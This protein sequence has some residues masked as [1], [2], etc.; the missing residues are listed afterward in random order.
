MHIFAAV[1]CYDGKVHAATMDAFLGEMI[2][3]CHAGHALQVQRLEGCSSIP[4][5]RNALVFDFL[6]SKAD[7]LV[8]I[9]SDMAWSPGDLVRLASLPHDIV[10]GAY[11]YKRDGAGFIVHWDEDEPQLWADAHGAMRVKGLGCG[12]LAISR[13]ALLAIAEKSPDRWYLDAGEKV[14]AYFDMPFADGT[15]W[16]EDLRFCELARRANIPIHVLPEL[17]LTHCAGPNLGFKG[18]LG[19]WLRARM[20]NDQQQRVA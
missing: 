10:G 15:L 2:M 17:E 6:K 7:R 1:P 14:Y 11:R 3:A 12:F 13:K 19:D 20:A 5:A 18:R 9:D 8:F 16:G 4:S